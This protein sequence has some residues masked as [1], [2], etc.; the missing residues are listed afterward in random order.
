MHKLY[1]YAGR[2]LRVN[3][4]S[5]KITKELLRK[6]LIKKF[7][8]GTG[9]CAKILW[10]ELKPRIDPYQPDNKLIFATGPLTGTL[11]QGSGRMVVCSKS[12]LTNCWAES[13]IGGFF[14]PELK[15]AGYDALI[16]EGVSKQPVILAVFDDDVR[17]QKASAIWGLKTSATINNIRAEYSDTEVMCIGPAG[18]NLVRFACI[19]T[20]YS[21]AAGRCGLGA[22]MGSKKLKAIVVKGTGGFEIAHPDKFYDFCID[23]HKRLITNVQNNQ[24]TKYGTPLLVGYKSEIGELVTKNHQ[25]GIFERSAL[26][27]A[28]TLR[29]RYFVKTRACYGCRTQ[30]KKVYRI[31][32][33]NKYLTG[34][35]P[36]YEG[37]MALGTNCFNSDFNTVFKGNMLCNELGMDVI[38]TGSVIAFTFECIEKGI[39]NLKDYS[40]KWGDSNTILQLIED[41]GYRRKF[42]AVLAE[43]VL[44]SAKIIGKNAEKYAM[45]VKGMEISGQDGRAHRSAGLTHAISVRGADHLRSLVTVDQ[46]GYIDI[47]A[48]R[49]G[50]D[51][52]PEICNP[53]T[54]TY[55]AFAVCCAEDTY[56][57]RD[58]II[59][60]WYTCGWPPIFWIDDFAKI[61]YYA[62]G[63]DDF[64]DVRKIV[65]I[66][67]RIVML[68]RMFNIR[69]GYSKKDDTL[70]DRFLKEPM[71]EGPAKGQVVNLD[72]MLQEY[73]RLR[74][75]DKTG[76]MCAPEAR[77]LSLSKEFA[78]LK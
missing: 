63:I 45:H 67:Q 70:P 6:H 64:Q 7:I 78:S 28:E 16:I 48:K 17:I 69:E 50:K 58:S 9:L 38:S 59:T 51:K 53:Y 57:L 73:Y 68:R 76:R 4:T 1:G 3:L 10:D 14:G 44:R 11:W 49:F 27:S 42:G 21:N 46:L 40:A 12:P 55:K 30:C 56:A 34:G 5:G 2:I 52:V 75:I 8:G 18:E 26:L 43:G 25:T 24:L 47:A 32:L 60:C 33:N 23:A 37:I 72:I 35:G 65:K 29:K 22:V 74:K 36:E 15:F 54:E 41:I 71:P 31:K 13:H 39:L 77:R 62:T 20:N 19:I 61:L 66:G